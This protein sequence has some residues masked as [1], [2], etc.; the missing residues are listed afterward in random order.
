MEQIVQKL[1]SERAE[2]I[3]EALQTLTEYESDSTKSKETR[4]LQELTLIENGRVYVKLL[5]QAFCCPPDEKAKQEQERLGFTELDAA[6]LR[7]SSTR[8]LMHMARSKVVADFLTAHS[9]AKEMLH[10]ALLTI[11]YQ[12]IISKTNQES[13]DDDL[14]FVLDVFLGLISF[15]RTSRDFRSVIISRGEIMQSAKTI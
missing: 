12:K 9:G 8:A 6:F 1:K 2:Q 4:L 3:M 11:L 13:S 14:Q 10:N 15:V 7:G 5:K